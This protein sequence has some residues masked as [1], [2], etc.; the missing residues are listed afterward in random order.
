MAWD[1][2]SVRESDIKKL[3]EKAQEYLANAPP[4]IGSMTDTVHISLTLSVSE[5]HILLR[6]LMEIRGQAGTFQGPV[7]INDPVD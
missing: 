1:K 5:A 3:M 2:D 7:P 4:T 6:K